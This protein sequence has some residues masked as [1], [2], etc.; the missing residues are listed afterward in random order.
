MSKKNVKLTKGVVMIKSY[1]KTELKSL[2]VNLK[3]IPRSRYRKYPW[4]TTKVGSAFFVPR[5]AVNRDNYI[6]YT[7]KWLKPLGYSIKSIKGVCPK[8]GKRG[9]WYVRVS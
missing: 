6:L 8:T 2:G 4:H 1:S 3:L 7:P 9:R 5:S